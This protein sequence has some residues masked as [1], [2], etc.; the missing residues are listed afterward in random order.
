MDS[1]QTNTMPEVA[2]APAAPA[3]RDTTGRFLTGGNGGP[4][5]PK[6]SK[7]RLAEQF[8]AALTADFEQH[9]P[10]A[11]EAVRRIDPTGYLR[12]ITAVVGRDAT[13]LSLSVQNQCRVMV[14]KD[15]G[16]DEEWAAKLREQQER[17]VR[18]AAVDV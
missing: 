15:F 8:L 2:S 4:G 13:K 5:R 7:N 11:I 16:T 6:G 17:L 1:E 18:E 14:I 9:G 12:I 3:G 10:A